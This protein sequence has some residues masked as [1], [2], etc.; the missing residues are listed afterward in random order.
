M[1]FIV[2]LVL[3]AVLLIA[4]PSLAAATDLLS[5]DAF[6]GV[7][8]AGSSAGSGETSWLKRGLGK[9]QAGGDGAVTGSAIIAWRS[10]IVGRLGA[11]ASADMHTQADRTVG[12]DE[13]YLTW[14]PAPGDALRLSGRAGLFFPPVSLEH[15]GVKWFA[16]RTLTPSAIDTWI[17]EEVKVAG[18][19]TT[20]RGSIAGRPAGVTA[21]AFQAND[22]SGALLTFRG[23]ALHD[24]RANLDGAFPLPP[25]P[26]MFVGK[27][28][29]KTRPVDEVDGRWGAY[30]RLEYVPVKTL[31]VSL[32][33]YDNNGDRT[34]V[35]RGQY[36]W[37]TRF[38]QVSARWSP[39]RNT[40]VLAQVM[41]GQT[42]MGVPVN[43]LEPADIGFAAAYIL[44]SR[45][46]PHGT[47]TLRLDQFS[48]SDHSFK[49]QDNNAEHGWATTAAWGMPLLHRL[50]L[51]FEGVVVQSTRRDRMRFG[52]GASQTNVQGRAAFRT[53]F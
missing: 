2:G 38:A 25:I 4:S 51:V 41:T 14:K 7:I 1:K 13:A 30:A 37:R 35:V 11:V 53:M 5:R 28:A 43:G 34:T 42:A 21:A 22:T 9:L 12:L 50:D 18:V 26:A 24:L 31:T 36:A 47:A 15:D 40:E 17:A 20:L 10:D 39:G 45:T 27:Q 19:E 49:A 6:S 52:L 8:V 32:L 33:G 3:P 44:V 23:S 46:T 29:Q 48:V 16:T